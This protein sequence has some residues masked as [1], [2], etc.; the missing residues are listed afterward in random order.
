MLYDRKSLIFDR[1]L[2]IC[3]KKVLE[4]NAPKKEMEKRSK[5]HQ[6]SSFGGR[7]AHELQSELKTDRNS[8]AI[9]P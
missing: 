8:C 4:K 3:F 2:M 6:K 5:T 9:R 7:I 1:Y